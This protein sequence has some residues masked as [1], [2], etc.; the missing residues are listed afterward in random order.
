MASQAHVAPVKLG[1][2][3]CGDP[4]C[5]SCKLLRETEERI[6]KDYEN[7]GVSKGT[8]KLLDTTSGRTIDS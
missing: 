6:S 1:S 7:A 3:Y 4:N 8:I 5:E 2:M